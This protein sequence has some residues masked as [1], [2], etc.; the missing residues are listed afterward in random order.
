MLLMVFLSS[1]ALIHPF[2]FI[3]LSLTESHFTP[4]Q[5]VELSIKSRHKHT[6]KFQH[7]LKSKRQFC[8]IYSVFHFPKNRIET[9]L[10]YTKLNKE[11]QTN[12]LNIYFQKVDRGHIFHRQLSESW[13]FYGGL[14]RSSRSRRC[15]CPS[16][17]PGRPYLLR[18]LM[19]WNITHIKLSVPKVDHTV[20]L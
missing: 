4:T 14:R 15:L 18:V 9:P 5:N 1:S 16:L 8:W 17:L 19:F 20:L 10:V 6:T 3:W 11:K 2:P 7:N 13:W 12:L